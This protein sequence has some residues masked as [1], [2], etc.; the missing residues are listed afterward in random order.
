MYQRKAKKSMLIVLDIVETKR[1]TSNFVNS[2]PCNRVNLFL[3]FVVC[4]FGVLEIS[5]C[6]G[7]GLAF[8]GD[9][10]DGAFEAFSVWG[11]S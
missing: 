2:L 11:G 5:V 8:W 9:H 4:W 10:D 6:W 1:L 7:G 3:Y